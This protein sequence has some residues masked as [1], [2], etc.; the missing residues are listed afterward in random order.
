MK[1][2]EVSLAPGAT[3]AGDSIDLPTGS[4][5]IAKVVSAV[6]FRGHAVDEG[7][8]AT[9]TI[10]PVSATP[11]KVDENTIKLDVDTVAEDILIVKYIPKGAIRALGFN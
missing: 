9:Y 3:T 8:T 5:P 10:G 6:I 2:V 1:V 4:P 7:G 11:T